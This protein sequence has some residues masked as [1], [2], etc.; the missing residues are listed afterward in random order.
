MP[1]NIRG[2][3]WSWYQCPKCKKWMP[4]GDPFVH[5]YEMMHVSYSVFDKQ[6]A[7]RKLIDY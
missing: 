5:H 3:W 4:E 2:F 7:R 1:Y 6:M